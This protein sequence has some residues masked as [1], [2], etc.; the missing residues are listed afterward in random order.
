MASLCDGA[1]C[2]GLP[3]TLDGNNC[4]T[5]PVEC[6]NGV[7]VVRSQ[8]VYQ[9][10][11]AASALADWAGGGP[12]VSMPNGIQTVIN[13]P[14]N[15]GGAPLLSIDTVNPFCS[16]ANVTFAV[17]FAG[18]FYVSLSDKYQFRGDVSITGATFVE[19]QPPFTSQVFPTFYQIPLESNNIASADDGIVR[20]KE[21]HHG[22]TVDS[23]V[24]AGANFNF[25]AL[26]VWTTTPNGLF[27]AALSFNVAVSI[28]M[29]PAL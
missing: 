3:T 22:Y 28:I 18:R 29:S 5:Q 19:S 1:D 20:D 2:L 10:R 8:G 21:F 7:A 12:S 11:Y 16:A 26:S 14:N 24:P 9:R 13:G 25:K 17:E 6:K 4:Y 27:R 23:I 15:A